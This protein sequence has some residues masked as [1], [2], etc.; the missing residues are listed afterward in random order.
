MNRWGYFLIRWADINFCK[1]THFIKTTA[2]FMALA[3]E[4]YVSS[5]LLN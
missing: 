3:Q 5:Q 4:R 2:K 1:Q